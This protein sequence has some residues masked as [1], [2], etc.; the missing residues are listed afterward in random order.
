MKS[1]L[2]NTNEQI[3]V[4]CYT[5]HA[6][7]QFLLG[8]LGYTSGEDIVR[9]GLQSKCTELDAYNLEAKY[10]YEKL[11]GKFK[12]IIYHLKKD[13]IE[14]MD[15]IKN[16]HLKLKENPQDL[17]LIKQLGEIQV[18]EELIVFE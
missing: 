7:D 10:N 2:K 3:L 15:Q 6:L 8:I 18:G 5:N 9:I 16:I 14:A 11:D 4:I 1:L 17:S 12:K 13:R